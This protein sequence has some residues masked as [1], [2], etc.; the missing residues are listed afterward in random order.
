LA[1][2]FSRLLSQKLEELAAEHDSVVVKEV[3]AWYFS[4]LVISKFPECLGEK[5]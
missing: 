1:F 4:S 2:A 5:E 3:E